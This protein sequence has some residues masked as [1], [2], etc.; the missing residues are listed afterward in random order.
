[1]PSSQQLLDVIRIQADIAKLGLDLGGVMSLVVEQ[2][3]GLIGADGAA[4][5]LAEG[6]DMVYRA[7]S[8]SAAA[9]I[10]LRLKLDSSLSGLCVRTGETLRCDDSENDDRV[11]REACRRVG[12]R[13]MIV[14]PLKHN[15][16]TV[17]ALKAMSALPSKFSPADMELLGLLSDVVGA[18]MFFAAKYDTDDLFHRATHDGLTGLA[19]RSLFMDR[20]RTLMSQSERELR[21]A[22]LLMIDMDGLKQVNDNFGHRAGDAVIVEFAKRIKSGARASDTVA[23]LGGDEFGIILAPVDLPHGSETAVERLTREIEPPFHF[24]GNLYHLRASIGA[25][26]YPDEGCDMG[27]LIELADRRMYVVKKERRGATRHA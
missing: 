22:A 18:A 13:S 26:H 16:L 19:N 27:D 24:E 8:G 2:T 23:R 20:L 5:E 1:M 15:G 6:E 11:D 14:M 3:L 25:A 17:G 10:G 21:P 9:Q 4:I 12:L 7:A